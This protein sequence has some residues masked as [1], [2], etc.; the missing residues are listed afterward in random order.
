MKNLS[1]TVNGGRAKCIY[2][3]LRN[4]IGCYVTLCHNALLAGRGYIYL[5]LSLFVLGTLQST[6]ATST[7]TSPQNITLHYRKFLA[8]RPSSSRSTMW[9]EYPKNKLVRAV[10]E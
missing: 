3:G 2:H 4:L 9:A 5:A 7:K 10:S 1:D 8:V 6:T